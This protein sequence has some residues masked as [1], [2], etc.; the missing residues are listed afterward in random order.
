MFDQKYRPLLAFN[1]LP[2]TTFRTLPALGEGFKGLFQPGL[3]VPQKKKNERET[4]RNTQKHAETRRN[5]TRKARKAAS[6]LR[7]AQV[8]K[9][10][11]IHSLARWARRANGQGAQACLWQG[12]HVA[13]RAGGK[14]RMWQ[15]AQVARRERLSVPAWIPHTLL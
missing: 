7:R 8:D 6:S 13:R 9:N 11:R 14:T 10:T 4:P 15:G 5:Q 1:E 2:Q 3:P 12:A